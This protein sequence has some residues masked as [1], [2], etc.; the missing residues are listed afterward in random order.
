MLCNIV[1]ERGTSYIFAGLNT[2][3]L[4]FL[5]NWFRSEM[6]EICVQAYDL[7]DAYFAHQDT[8]TGDGC[9]NCVVHSPDEKFVF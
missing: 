5:C 7:Y 2:V 6:L 9:D 1:T 3:F 8:I 4:L